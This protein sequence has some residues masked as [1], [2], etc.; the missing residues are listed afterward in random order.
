[1]RFSLMILMF[2]VFGLSAQ[3]QAQ[4][5]RDPSGLLGSATQAAQA[6]AAQ[7]SRTA[8][9][10]IDPPILSM[11]ASASREV[12]NDRMVVVL[13]AEREAADAG[14]AQAEVNQLIGPALDTL[15]RADPKLEIETV[16]WRS[17]PITTD[18]QIRGWRAR[19]SLRVHGPASDALAARV[20]TLSATLG[21]E[22]L[23]H[24]LS[25]NTRERIEAELLTEVSTRFQDKARAA[26]RALGYRDATI[27][28]VSLNQASSGPPILAARSGT[29][30]AIA[31][32]AGPI[33]RAEG[34]STVSLT[35]EGSVW[36][37]R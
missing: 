19:A 14:R 37:Q 3:A 34:S 21:I 22:S 26:A 12:A 23:R 6:A 16:G 17:W 33:A 10:W 5:N 1:M 18:G 36:L 4:D 27:R 28:M 8:R 35:L 31:T 2:W 30:M 9:A 7:A 15:R 11:A 25:R 29:A 20:G 32:G 24:E 13:Y